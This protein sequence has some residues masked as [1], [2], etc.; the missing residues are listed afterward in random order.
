MSI[1]NDK[2]AEEWIEK[3]HPENG[4]FRVYWTGVKGP[5][6]GGATL[7][8]DESEGLRYEWYY[9]DG[10]RADGKTRG[11]RPNGQLKQEGTYKNGKKDGLQTE[12]Y[13]NGQVKSKGTYKNGK[14]C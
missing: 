13:E 5:N 12:W 7:D 3:N 1:I 9:K 8:P 4:L 6:D 2:P 14:L 11:W 10:K